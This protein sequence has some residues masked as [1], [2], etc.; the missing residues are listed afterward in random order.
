MPQPALTFFGGAG[1]KYLVEAGDARV[2][3][4]CGLFQGLAKLRRRNR[5]P[6]PRELADIDAVVITH[7]HLDHPRR[8]A[9]NDPPRARRTRKRRSARDTPAHGATR[10]LP[11]QRPPAHGTVVAAGSPLPAARPSPSR[12]RLA[13]GLMAPGQ[14]HKR[15][16]DQDDRPIRTCPSPLGAPGRRV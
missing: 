10:P 8:P 9:R 4:D 11:R 3:V 13:D 16:G 15:R 5:A 14:G 1:S 7:A 6:L 2:L 12:S